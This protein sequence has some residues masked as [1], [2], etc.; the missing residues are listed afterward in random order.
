MLVKCMLYRKHFDVCYGCG[1]LGHRADVCPYPNDKVCRES[2]SGNPAQDHRCEVECKLC[3][4]DH[5]TGDN[6]CKERYKIPYL[7]RRR[8]CERTRRDEEEARAACAEACYQY[9]EVGVCHDEDHNT[10]TSQQ[11]DKDTN[12]QNSANGHAQDHSAS[13]SKLTGGKSLRQSRSRSKSRSRPRSHSRATRGSGSTQVCTNE[14]KELLSRDSKKSL[15]LRNKLMNHTVDEGLAKAIE[16]K[17]RLLEYDRTSKRR[18]KV[19]DDNSDYYSSDNKWLTLE[20]REMIRK[21]E[22]ELYAEQHASR[23]QQKVTLDFAGR[24]VVKEDPRHASMQSLF[25]SLVEPMAEININDQLCREV[26]SIHFVDPALDMPPFEYVPTAVLR[27]PTCPMW[28]NSLVCTSSNG[29][30]I[31]SR[32][33]DRALMEMS[34]DGFALSV[35][36]PFAGLLVAGIKKHEGR[37]WFTTYRG[38]LW[39]HAACKQP[40]QE[41]I[42]EVTGIYRQIV[43]AETEELKFPDEY[44]TNCL[45]G[46]VNL[47]DCLPQDTYREQYPFGECIS[48]FVFICE[49][50][51]GL[52]TKLPMKGQHKICMLAFQPHQKE[53]EGLGIELA[54]PVQCHRY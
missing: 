17:N 42:T 34:D 7:V 43:K 1:R 32:I 18:T 15:E 54:H 37:A 49:R 25:Q 48:P 50:P 26:E 33:Q 10:T 46:C 53:T 4:K 35:Q 23:R 3:G 40:S 6:R 38:R 27:A 29:L 52:K 47:V 31:S 41:D 45:L 8:R 19:I 30:V 22:E 44:P 28:D 11:S 5:P 24:Q 2:G 16:Q 21:K 12:R 9:K 14:E 51:Q 20:Q 39:I 36:Q 13:F